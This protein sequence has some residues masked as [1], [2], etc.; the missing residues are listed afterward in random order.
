MV[1]GRKMRSCII[2]KSIEGVGKSIIIE[3]LKY[4]VLGKGLVL[5]TS[6]TSIFTG[7]FNSSLIG[8]ML[9]VLEE[10]PCATSGEW[11]VMDS[12]LKH[13]IT[14]SE[15][16]I[17]AMHKEHKQMPNCSSFILN[18]NKE[19]LHM[20]FDSRRYLIN[21]M[22]FE[23]KGNRKYFATLLEAMK[24]DDIGEAFYF[25]CLEIAEQ[26][27]NFDEQDDKPITN[28]FKR[29]VADNAPPLYR[30]IKEKYV[31][32]KRGINMKYKDF[33]E[34]FECWCDEKKIKYYPKKG[35][36][37]TKLLELGINY[38]K[39]SS[40]HNNNNW[41]E[42]SFED[43]KKI[44]EEKHLLG[45]ADEINKNVND[46]DEDFEFQ[47]DEEKIENNRINP[48]FTREEKKSDQGF[49]YE[50]WEYIPTKREYV[51]YVEVKEMPL[52]P[53]CITQEEIKRVQKTKTDT[54]T[55]ELKN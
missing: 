1:S 18:T 2:N 27:P 45:D 34:K 17:R 16:T 46:I 13:Y 55:E 48:L 50:E 25:H 29:N 32:N 11:H 15:M 24:S 22:S 20:N 19:V 39:M 42:N 21:D 36:C 30:Y 53:P 4:K 52:I 37:V 40:K 33:Y 35:E 7:Q 8:K 28:A 10:A 9:V 44:F 38:L 26:N 51:K 41:I 12:K 54:Y 47:D 3:F 43:L 6:D 31:L 5:H 23:K 14:E 49:K